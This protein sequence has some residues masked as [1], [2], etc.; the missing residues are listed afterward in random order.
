MFSSNPGST[1]SMPAA[2]PQLRQLK[3]SLV[4]AKCSLEGK[5][6]PVLKTT[7]LNNCHKTKHREV[8]EKMKE[9][10]RTHSCGEGARPC[11]KQQDV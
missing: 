2:P 4:I 5:I 7:C 6:A 1:H 9:A 11:K 10:G 8:N 3:L